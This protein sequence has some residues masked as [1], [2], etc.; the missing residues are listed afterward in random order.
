MDLITARLIIDFG[1]V[2]LI[3]MV[4]LVVYPSFLYYT[5]T[6]LKKWHQIYTKQITFVVAPL[7]FAQTGVIAA[8]F[9]NNL[10]WYSVTSALVCASLWLLTFFEAVPLHAQ[11]DKKS[12]LNK[13]AKKLVRIN[14][15]RTALWTVLFILSIVFYYLK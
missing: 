7:M 13:I 3:W 12:N 2:V 14:K 4:Q 9:I 1:A 8:Q 10:N 5:E 6:N 11:I 15:K